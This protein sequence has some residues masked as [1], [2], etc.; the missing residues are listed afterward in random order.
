MQRAATL[1]MMAILTSC[2]G[3]AVHLDRSR[4]ADG[5]PLA[6]D[7]E[8]LDAG[9][10]AHADLGDPAKISTGPKPD[11][12]QPVGGCGQWSAWTC[13]EL[14]VVLCKATCATATTSYSVSCLKNGGCVC[15]LTPGLCGPYSY[16]S[17]CDACRQAFE[18]GCCKTPLN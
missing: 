14:P 4:L 16:A 12:K 15:G 6:S 13:Q 1:I 3:E 10:T 18:K 7:G 2:A 8:W 17:P 11:A 5:S 9:V